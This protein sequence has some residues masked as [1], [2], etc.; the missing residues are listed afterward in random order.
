VTIPSRSAL[1]AL[2]ATAVALAYFAQGQSSPALSHYALV[3]SLAR[4]TAI[5]DETREETGDQ[6]T[7]DVAYFDG[8]YYSNKA[9]GLAFLVLPAYVALDALGV[10][11][12]GDPL[13]MLWALSLVGAVLPAMAL[14]L[15]V[16]WFGERL[17]PGYGT[18][19]AITLGL[20]TLLTPF[21]T[22][23]FPHVLSALLI[24]TAFVVLF[25]ER[26]G[27][28]RPTLLAAAGLLAGYAITTEYH[29]LFAA[30]ILGLFA[31]WRANPLKRALVYGS[32]VIAGIT[33]LLLY[34][35]WAFGSVAHLSYQGTVLVAGSSGHDDLFEVDEALSLPPSLR[36]AGSLLF[37][38]WG[39]FV[40]APVL[41]L[42]AAALVSVY[43]R[44]FRA[45][46]IVAGSACAAYLVYNAAY[47]EPFGQ[48]QP[49]PRFLIPLLPFLAAPLA[50]SFRGAQS[51]TLGLAALSVAVAGAVTA[52]R[53]HIAWD[54][55]VLYRLTHPSWW[56]P[57]IA[58]LVGIHGWFRILPAVTAFSIAILFA[59]ITVW[60][61]PEVEEQ[62]APQGRRPK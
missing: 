30:A 28:P 2:V 38:R 36:T 16:R 19:A 58:D 22:V 5:I 61:R 62:R 18:A 60:R 20:G 24:F 40:A 26:Q 32:G 13:L 37:S 44:G 35:L 12:T 43:R 9:P 46:A 42:G 51:V 4:G 11:T 7:A 48:V 33:P 39:L 52:T 31:L 56:S 59:V 14:L 41:A 8:H 3:K 6:R 57:T 23:L 1:A 47:Y 17:E 15:I 10:R 45:E 29:N 49:G 53:P 54:G 55:D 25:V 34:N 50:L 27:D 21:A